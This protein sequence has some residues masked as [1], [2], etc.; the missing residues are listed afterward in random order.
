[1]S[2]TSQEWWNEVKADPAKFTHWLVRQYVGEVTAASRI[3]RHLVPKART[4]REESILKIIADQELRHADWISE[5]LAARG[6]RADMAAAENR[7]W[8]A[9]A[10]EGEIDFED[11]SALA[12]HAEGMRLERIRVIAEDE[13]APEDVQ[14][15]FIRILR[16]EE[17]HERAFRKMAGDEAMTNMLPHHQAGLEVLGLS[18]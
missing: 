10:P 14:N 11:T 7:Y 18:A 12:A 15:T 3:N 6:I 4:S 2:K 9:V 16:E 13:S 5:L 1:M 17:F 8:A